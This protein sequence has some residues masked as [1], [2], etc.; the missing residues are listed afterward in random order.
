MTK[1]RR[2][3]PT[4]L[5]RFDALAKQV[6]NLSMASRLTQ[7]MVQNINRHIPNLETSLTSNTGMLNDFQYRLLAIQQL[8]GLDSVK[9]QEI[10]DSLKLS[11]FEKESTRKDLEGNFAVGEEVTSDEDT[12]IITTTTP[13]EKED[14]GI[15]RSRIKISEMNQ[16]DLAAKLRGAKVGTK[17]ES[18]LNGVKHIVEVLGIRSE[19]PKVEAVEEK[20]S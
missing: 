9:L 7:M 1:G 11:D 18:V 17:V 4:K 15:L 20:A 16:A 19:P 5:E 6:E 14:H 8:L 2:T 10:T 13:D 12:V 3:K